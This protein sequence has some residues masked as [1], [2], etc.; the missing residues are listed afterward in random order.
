M[1]ESICRYCDR[2]RYDNFPNHIDYCNETCEK[3]YYK[4]Y[5]SIKDC[6]KC[7]I[8]YYDLNFVIK[9]D[10][11][12]GKEKFYAS[13]PDEK[14][15]YYGIVKLRYLAILKNIPNVEKIKTCKTLRK[16][17]KGKV[18]NTDFPIKLV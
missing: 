2:V 17:L 6:V 15:E 12:C 13:S 14:L 8:K 9:C 7:F 1:I 4:K 18:S 3:I 16:H 10:D 11:C 5:Y